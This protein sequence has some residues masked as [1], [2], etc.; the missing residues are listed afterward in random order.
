MTNKL[1]KYA[2][3]KSKL[4]ELDSTGQMRRLTDISGK[5]GKYINVNGNNYLNLSSNDYLGLSSDGDLLEEFAELVNTNHFI[6]KYG[7]TSASSRLLTGNHEQFTEIET[8]LSSLYK[9]ESSLVFNSGY[10]ANIGILPALAH[11]GD[12]ILSDKLNHASIID[13]IRLSRADYKRYNHLDY[14][15]LE[16]LLKENKEKYSNIFIVS[17]SIFSMD[18]DRADLKKLVELKNK[19][20]AFLIVD[21]A[22]AVGVCGES[23]LGIAE[24]D[25]VISDIDIIVATFGKALASLGAYAVMD[26]VIKDYLINTMRPLI[27]STA[28]P[29]F[30]LFWTLFVLKKIPEMKLRRDSLKIISDYFSNELVNIGFETRGSSHIV[31]V[32]IG[33]NNKTVALSKVLKE[34]GLWVMPIRPP[35]VPENTSRLRISLSSLIDE[36]DINNLI[37]ILKEN[38]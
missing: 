4:N 36:Q 11:K 25:D 29:A 31:P 6:S 1:D 14:T 26:K 17:E 30:N 23:G 15:Q 12:L 9:R 3:Y 19:Y 8:Y 22:H 37:Y 16:N 13:G 33:D 10:H 27:F 24:E 5:S 28:L 35:S 32:I 21:E 38:S 18:G 20:N 34:S 7:M 2:K